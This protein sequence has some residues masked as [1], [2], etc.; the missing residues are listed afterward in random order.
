MLADNDARYQVDAERD[1]VFG[2]AQCKRVHRRQEEKVEGEHRGDGNRDR[3]REAADDS[4]RDD[5]D[6]I[7]DAETDDRRDRSQRI[8]PT[9]HDR[10]RDEAEEDG[11][12][13][14]RRFSARPC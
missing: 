9:S 8:Y 7:E 4:N 2:L 14:V 6:H 5:R 13:S 12:D 3:V 11:E 1:P 10:N